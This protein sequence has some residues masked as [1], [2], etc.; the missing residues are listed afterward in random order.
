MS[1]IEG[2]NSGEIKPSAEVIARVVNLGIESGRWRKESREDGLTLLGD[3]CKEFGIQYKTLYT[4]SDWGKGIFL[5]DGETIM[6][7]GVDVDPELYRLTKAVTECDVGKYWYNQD[8]NS[9]VRVAYLT[10][11]RIFDKLAK[12]K[13]VSS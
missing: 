4:T 9:D 3:A 11:Y 10:A 8:D 13:Q 5:T 6:Q 12:N 1:S 7:V 2:M